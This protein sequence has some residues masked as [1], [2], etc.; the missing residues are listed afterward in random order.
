MNKRIFS[1]FLLLVL[2]VMWVLPATAE[3]DSADCYG[4]A[5]REKADFGTVNHALANYSID[6]CA[7]SGSKSKMTGF[8]GKRGF[9]DMAF[10]D[11][12]ADGG[13]FA[14]HTVA[15]RFIRIEQDEDVP[16]FAVVIRGTEKPA[17]WHS[18]LR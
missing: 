18:N 8:L 17:E 7:L 2:S 5:F 13:H 4:Q 12:E 11:F 10:Y 3:E 15:W 14:A 6:A 16:L 9:R 1:V